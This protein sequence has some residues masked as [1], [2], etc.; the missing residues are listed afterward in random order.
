[1]RILIVDDSPTMRRMIMNVLRLLDGVIFDEAANGL[2]AL[3]R[4]ALA[5]PDLLILDLNMPDMNGMD[6]IRFLRSHARYHE[7]PILVLT[8]R[9]DPESREEAL[10]AGADF[11]MAKPFQPQ[12]LLEEVRALTTVVEPARG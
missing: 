2:E 8:T 6:V 1:M 10:A 5:Q 4:I 9:G 12:Q 11:Y 3:E 7:L